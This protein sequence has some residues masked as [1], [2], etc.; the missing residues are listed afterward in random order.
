MITW[1][2]KID[3]SWVYDYTVF[4]QYVQFCMDRGI[5]KQISCFSMVPWGNRHY[6]LDEASGNL[7]Y[8]TLAPNTTDYNQHWEPFF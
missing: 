7:V 2:K 3:G 5:N 8:K 6:Y 1:T 4:D